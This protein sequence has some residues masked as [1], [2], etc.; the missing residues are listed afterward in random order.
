MSVTTRPRTAS[1]RNSSRSFVTSWSC[2]NAKE[3]CVSAAVRIW[4]SWNVTPRASSSADRSEPPA[5][6][7][8]TSALDLH[9]SAT[10]V[11]AA[12]RAHAVRDLRLMALRALRVRGGLG[13]PVRPA[14]G[15]AAVTLSTLRYRHRSSLSSGSVVLAERVERVPAGIDRVIARALAE[16]AVPAA[17]R[18]EPQ[19]VRT[20]ER[21]EGE[22]EHDRVPDDRLGVERQVRLERVVVLRTRLA[23][24]HLV[25]VD[26]EIAV[27]LLQ[28]AGAPEARA[29]A[30]RAGDVDPLHDAL[31]RQLGGD[32]PVVR[33]VGELGPKTGDRLGHAHG[34]RAARVLEEIPDVDR[35]HHSAS[36]SDVVGSPDSPIS[37]SIP[38]WASPSAVSSGAVA[39]AADRHILRPA[40]TWSIVR[41]SEPFVPIISSRIR[42]S[43]A[44][45]CASFASM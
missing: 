40:C 33:H 26:R 19:A 3:R 42:C 27:E 43:V 34:A 11:V 12:V 9:G 22:L 28:A 5:R 23:N 1:P 15:P 4:G 13:L 18:A 41:A 16:V 8:L 37:M 32:G 10:R 45:N 35:A 7:R 31:E 20:A 25:H 21:R 39:G 24:D 6:R 14:L 29:P 36:S 38:D 30:D 44:S 17:P 2:S